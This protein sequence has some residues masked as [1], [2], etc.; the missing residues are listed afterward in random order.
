MEKF[1]IGMEN[2]KKTIYYYLFSKIEKVLKNGTI[3]LKQ[4]RF[5]Y[6][7]E[8]QTFLHK[9]NRYCKHD[10]ILILFILNQKTR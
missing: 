4:R 7:N 9:R 8:N 10:S 5:Q 3:L 1:V 2:K 6:L